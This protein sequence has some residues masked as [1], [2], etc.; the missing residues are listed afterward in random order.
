[1]DATF[2]TRLRAQRERQQ[3]TLDA[4]ADRTKIRLALLEGLERDDVSQWPTGIFRR[5][6]LRSYASA[7]GLDPEV[8]VREF[9]ARYPDTVE[10]PE[11]AL[12]AHAD[13]ERGGRR[14]P[15]RLQYLIASALGAVPKAFG[16]AKG[17]DDLPDTRV[18]ATVTPAAE[19]AA[20]PVV[21]VKD[22][23]TAE[24]L[25]D[26]LDLAC[27]QASDAAVAATAPPPLDLPAMAA[28]CRHLA[29]ADGP[30]ELERHL[31][32][33]AGI[34]HAAGIIV[35]PWD[36][37]RAALW[38]SLSYGYPRQLLSRLPTLSRDADNPI[39]AAFRTATLQVVAGSGGAT[40]AIAVPL[41]TARGC[42]GVLAIECAGGLEAD[43]T[44]QALATILAAQ[45]SL[46]VDAEPLA[47]H[48]IA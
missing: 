1:M 15:M 37:S 11:E 47:H 29:G 14:P 18:T 21:E 34:L 17:A 20:A 46:L 44:R 12:A 10:E 16:R 26:L 25:H 32:T 35:W 43:D 33:A 36:A 6:Y 39:G 22:D 5:S 30:A 38:P 3:I 31:E 13:A 41:I 28:L 27:E 40:S 4:I 48:A 19:L 7:I 24:V 42:T 8:T 45:L 9:L 2:G 23:P